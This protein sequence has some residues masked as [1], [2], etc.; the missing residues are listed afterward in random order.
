MQVERVAVAHEER[1][2]RR[3]RQEGVDSSRDVGL[4]DRLRLEQVAYGRGLSHSAQIEQRDHN[5]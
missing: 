4:E 1:G 3:I 5:V 2:Q